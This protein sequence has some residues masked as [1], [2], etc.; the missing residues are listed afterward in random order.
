IA[1]AW[2]RPIEHGDISAHADV[3]LFDVNLARLEELDALFKNQVQTL[4]SNPTAVYEAVCRA[5]LV[6][7]AV[8]VPG[9]KAPHLVTRDMLKDM[10]AGAVLVDIA[11]DQGGCF[12]TSKATSHDDPIYEVDGIV[13]YCV[14]NMPGAVP[15]TSTFALNNV[16]LPHT[17]NIANNGAVEA[18]RRDPH[19]LAGLNVMGG[20]I[21]YKAVADD[22]GLD[23]APAE[24]F[25]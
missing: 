15:R 17:L 7:G 22:L 16:T 14:A 18:M 3:E 1:Q 6:I 8:L 23:Y 2:Q 24:T 13:H 21:T 4:F 12:E 25:L 10:K 19:L 11:I 20:K 9:G 5:D